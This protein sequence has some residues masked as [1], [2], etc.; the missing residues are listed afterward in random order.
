ML[1]YIILGLTQG[2]TEFLP[3]SSSGHLVIMQRILGLAGEELVL[4]VVLHLGTV[5]SLLVFF[6][7]DIFKLLRNFR[8][9]LLILLVTVITGAIGISGKDFFKSMFSAPAYVS[10]GLLVTGAIL[11]LT[12]KTR[13]YKREDLNFKDALILG[14]TQ[15][16]A[17]V[18]GISRSGI[19]ISTL[20]LRGIKADTVFRFSFLASIPA[21]LGAAL[22]E[23]KDIALVYQGQAGN[24]IAGFIF[25]FLAGIIALS[26]LRKMI[27]DAKFYYFGYYCIT[28]ALL[29]FLFIR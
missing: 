12:K 2:L 18:P 13:G 14:V 8:W 25:S 23:A 22:L 10:L 15:A 21:I 19:T 27:L 7:K 3:V 26:L 24:L 28:V 9:V 1:K 16:I 29:M 11:I 20:L 5:L 6:H 4:S 17:I